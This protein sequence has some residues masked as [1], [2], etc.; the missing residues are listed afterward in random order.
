[1]GGHD[2]REN[3]LNQLLVEMDGE[4]VVNGVMGLLCQEREH[5]R[6]EPIACRE[7]WCW[8]VDGGR[9]EGTSCQEG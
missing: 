2:E 1:M 7:G 5:R 8:G 9:R 3:T 4:G 6:T